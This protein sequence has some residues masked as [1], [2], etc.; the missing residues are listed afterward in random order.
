MKTGDLIIS[1]GLLLIFIIVDRHSVYKSIHRVSPALRKQTENERT[2]KN[3][4][5]N[6]EVIEKGS[7][8]QAAPL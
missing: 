7:S 6:N 5:I 8:R 2:F 1:M 3:E 4:M